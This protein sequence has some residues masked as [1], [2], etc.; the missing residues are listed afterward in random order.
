MVTDTK[1]KIC[2]IYGKSNGCGE[3]AV[4]KGI[5]LGK[6]WWSYETF[7]NELLAHIFIKKR[8]SMHLYQLP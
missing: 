5:K 6:C 7:Q 4:V 8:K 2:P 1:E 3:K